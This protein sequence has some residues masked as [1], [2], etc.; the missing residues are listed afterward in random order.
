M[1]YRKFNFKDTA[2]VTQSV[3][4]FGLGVRILAATDLTTGGNTS[5]AKHLATGAVS[6]VLRDDH[7]KRMT[8]V[9]VGVT[10]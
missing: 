8:F 6:R 4:A 2:A 5:P 3:R 10:H 1:P 7:Y 9:T